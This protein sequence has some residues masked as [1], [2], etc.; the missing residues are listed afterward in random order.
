MIRI[1][2]L[3][4]ILIIIYCCAMYYVWQRAKYKVEARNREWEEK[5]KAKELEYE[6]R[7][8]ERAIEHEEHR[9]SMF[10]EKAIKEQSLEKIKEIQREIIKLEKEKGEYYK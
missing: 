9:I 8:L 7:F 3:F 4:L 1:V 6:I 2:L 5:K 10:G